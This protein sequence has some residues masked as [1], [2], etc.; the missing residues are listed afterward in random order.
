MWYYIAGYIAD[1][2]YCTYHKFVLLLH[3]VIT[4]SSQFAERMGGK[5][6][7]KSKKTSDKPS[8]KTPKKASKKAAKAASPMSDGTGS[9]SDVSGGGSD[10]GGSAI[11]QSKK[12]R[13]IS[14]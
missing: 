3:N 14:C 10:G 11:K 12:V 5:A 7:K 9:D 13:L 4:L 2:C 1:C 8:D 6:P